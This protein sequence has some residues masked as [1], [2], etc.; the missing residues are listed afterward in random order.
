MSAPPK[1]QCVAKPPTDRP[2]LV[3]RHAMTVR[4]GVIVPFALNVQSVETALSAPVTTGMIVP[5]VRHAMTA[6][7]VMIVGHSFAE[8]ARASIT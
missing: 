7:H 4:F 2:A 8:S 1:R 6:L 3:A 5:L